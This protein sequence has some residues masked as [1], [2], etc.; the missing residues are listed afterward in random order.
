VIKIESEETERKIPLTIT[1]TCR[2][3]ESLLQLDRPAYSFPQARVP[4]ITDDDNSGDFLDTSKISRSLPPI[5]HNRSD[6]TP[7]IEPYFNRN[8]C[9]A[10][11]KVGDFWLP[12]ELSPRPD[13]SVLQVSRQGGKLASV[14][15]FTVRV[16]PNYVSTNEDKAKH[17]V[18]VEFAMSDLDQ[19]IRGFKNIKVSKIFKES[20]VNPT[21]WLDIEFDTV[22]K[23][24]FTSGL[25]F[26][27]GQGWRKDT[28]DLLQAMQ[29]W[30]KPSHVQLRL[31]CDAVKREDKVE[32]LKISILA[33]K[34][35]A[36]GIQRQFFPC[37]SPEGRA[38]IERTQHPSRQNINNA[39]ALVRVGVSPHFRD[40][41]HAAIVF[42]YG[43]W[44]QDR[45][46]VE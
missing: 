10:Q 35:Q 28:V 33:E 3:A 23:G 45:F 14:L 15:V 25:D 30:R 29:G 5:L 38:L 39:H 8:Y 43:V 24:T 44:I 27:H 22:P 13:T 16:E 9:R 31:T 34:M 12:P 32:K 7:G 20:K 1:P 46:D 4:E 37:Y 41:D 17:Q 26:I 36:T 6:L 42:N 11:I 40:A 19:A 2:V 21:R 18:H